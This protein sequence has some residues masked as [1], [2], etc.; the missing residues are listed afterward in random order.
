LGAAPPPTTIAKQ[1]ATP[2]SQPGGQ[3]KASNE[4]KDF[5]TAEPQEKLKELAKPESMMRCMRAMKHPEATDEQM[6]HDVSLGCSEMDDKG[7]EAH[8]SH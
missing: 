7:E 3:D 2:S 4:A 1:L 5:L 6:G 8:S